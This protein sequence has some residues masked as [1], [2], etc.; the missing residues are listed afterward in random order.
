MGEGG[1]PEVLDDIMALD[2][3]LFLWSVRVFCLL[4]I[5]YVCLNIYVCECIDGCARRLRL[6]LFFLF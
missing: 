1:V 5:L 2:T 4:D 3:E 6:L